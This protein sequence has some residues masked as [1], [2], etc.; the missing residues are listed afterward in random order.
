LRKKLLN[1]RNKVRQHRYGF[2][3]FAFVFAAAVTG[4]A[5]VGFMKM[6]EIVLHFR[7]DFSN[8]G[9]LAFA[10]TPLVIV[11]SV[12]AARKYAPFARGT[13][14]PQ[15]LFGARHAVTGRE[16]NLQP[17]TSLRTIVVKIVTLLAAVAVGASTGREGPSVQIAACVFVSVMLLFRKLFGLEFE[18]R[19]ALIGGG[20][21]GLAAAFNTPLAGVVFA[22]EELTPGYFGA[23]KDL[24][25]MAIIVAAIAAKSLMGDY[26]YFGRV[27][28]AVTV[29]MPIIIAIGVAGGLAGAAFST[30]ILRGTRLLE[31]RSRTSTAWRIV[32]PVLFSLGLVGLSIVGGPHILGPGNGAAQELLNGDMGPWA[33]IFPLTKALA[34]LFTYLSGVSGGIFAPCL[35][36]GAAIGSSIG[37]LALVASETCAIVGMAA[38]LSGTIQAPMTAFVIIF[39]M[40]NQHNMLLPVML[41]AMI[42]FMVAR[43][44]KAQHL[45]DA[46]AAGY[47]SLLGPEGRKSAPAGESH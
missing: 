27:S 37:S 19:T 22:V 13:G 18:N 33:Y 46:L 29:P 24:A 31:D 15:V 1:F 43:L 36:I 35:A 32:P 3:L 2:L 7:V 25:L 23:L 17:L 9:M 5:V 28:D 40:T 38:F 6:F 47:D 8:A 26:F 16:T 44:V 14:I 41:G 30:A 34:T 12:E 21:A 42:A 45:Y 10:I 39:E 20:A 11:L 4:A